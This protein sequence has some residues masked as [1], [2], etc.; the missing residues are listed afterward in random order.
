[1][2]IADLAVSVPRILRVGFQ[3]ALQFRLELETTGGIRASVS[4]L[5]HD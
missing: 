4:P 5:D 2:L 3:K 1:M